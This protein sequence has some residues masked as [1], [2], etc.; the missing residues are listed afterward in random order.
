M[1]REGVRV[2]EK[3]L[4]LTQISRITQIYTDKKCLSQI[5][6]ISQIKND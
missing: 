5:T 6:L 4:Y 3:N 2:V 1:K